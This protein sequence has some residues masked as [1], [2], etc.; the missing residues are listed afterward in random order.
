VLGASTASTTIAAMAAVFS[1]EAGVALIAAQP[2]VA[3]VLASVG[4][5]GIE[6]AFGVATDTAGRSPEAIVGNLARSEDGQ[7]LLIRCLDVAWTATYD[8]KLLILGR[9][10]GVG[11]ED[12][13]KI[14]QEVLIVNA[15]AAL[16]PAHIRLLGILVQEHVRTNGELS[17]RFD[18]WM[19]DEPQKVDAALTPEMTQVLVS[20]LESQG[21][22]RLYSVGVN[23]Y[24]ATSLGHSLVARLSDVA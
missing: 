24:Q 17:D 5:R 14:D 1:P 3:E 21:L 11:A 10:L 6:R 4:R 7:R 19:I 23:S 9:C 20:I 12:G 15:V 16:E 22:V 8:E 18:N 13:A 2:I